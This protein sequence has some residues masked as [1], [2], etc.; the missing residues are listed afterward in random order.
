MK[1]FL[2]VLVGVALFA[3]SAMAQSRRAP[4][5]EKNIFGVQGGMNISWIGE[6]SS[7]AGFR[8]EGTY[9]RLL[10]RTMPLYLQTGLQITQKGAAGGSA[11]YFEV[12]IMVN[13]KFQLNRDWSIYPS[14]GFYTGLG[15]AG[16]GA[17][18][19]EGILKRGDFGM[20]FSGTAVWRHLTFG[21]GMEFGFIN[22]SKIGGNGKNCNFFLSVGYRF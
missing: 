1:K 7:T 22:I 16:D 2:L 4:R 3:G 15:F 20:G 12:P 19:D 9:E 21:L 14:A 6:A 17:F 18:G 8:V 10:T 13:Y 5:Y 11:W